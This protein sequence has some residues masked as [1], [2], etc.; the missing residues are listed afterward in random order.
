MAPNAA[1]PPAS[2]NA[3]P[4]DLEFFIESVKA[5]SQPR[6]PELEPPHDLTGALLGILINESAIPAAIRDTE[7]DAFTLAVTRLALDGWPLV[8]RAD[9]KYHLAAKGDGP[10]SLV[11]LRDR[12][13]DSP[14]GALYRE[15]CEIEAKHLFD[16]MN[17][18]AQQN[19]TFEHAQLRIERRKR[20]EA[21]LAQFTEGEPAN[22]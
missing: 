20:R 3:L 2:T 1:A 19:A 14:E 21:K 22:G 8:R 10:G 9:G 4:P 16:R 13:R 7:P 15:R 12:F 18:Y 6:L 11:D 17:F 5:T